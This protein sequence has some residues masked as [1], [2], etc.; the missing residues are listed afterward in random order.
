MQGE[1]SS[2]LGTETVIALTTGGA[3]AV[4][5]T[6]KVANQASVDVRYNNPQEYREYLAKEAGIPKHINPLKPTNAYGLD[7]QQL[8]TYFEINGYHVNSVKEASQGSGNAQVYAINNH[9]E[10]AKIQHS[11]STSNLPLKNRSQHEGEYIKFTLKK[12]EKDAAGIMKPAVKDAYGNSK[13]YIIDP[14]TFKKTAK[15][16]IFYNKQGQRLQYINR[17]YKVVK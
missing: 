9:P 15:D 6:V 5:K 7:S 17:E 1:L 10:I 11:P 8:R 14:T 13:V 2:I 16:S 12:A 3:V 4:A